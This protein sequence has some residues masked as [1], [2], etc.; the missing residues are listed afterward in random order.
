MYKLISIMLFLG[1][2][3]IF[4]Q[5]VNSYIELLRSD[6]KTE[7]KSIIMQVMQFSEEEASAFWTIY[8]EYEFELDK[9]GD[10]RVAFIKEFAENYQKMTDKKADEI[11]E[12]AFDFQEERLKLNRNLY[13]KLKEKLSPSKSAKFIQLE[14]QFELIIDLQIN[15]GLPLIE[16]S[17]NESEP[18]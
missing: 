14:H 6:V 11:M 4:A 13:K 9:L 18:K 7:K 5:D 10:K 17:N 12:R 2:S 15:A 1:I 8:R 3:S 16:K